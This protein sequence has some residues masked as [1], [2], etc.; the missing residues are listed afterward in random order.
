MYEGKKNQ[1]KNY[2]QT[3]SV[4][5]LGSSAASRTHKQERFAYDSET[6]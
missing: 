5:R 3:Q 4:C 6:N 1:I 2:G